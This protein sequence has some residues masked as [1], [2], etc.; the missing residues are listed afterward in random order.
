MA[1]VTLQESD[2]ARFGSLK[3]TPNSLFLPPLLSSNMGS[4]LPGVHA[5]GY[6]PHAWNFV[7]VPVAGLTYCD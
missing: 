7:T 6:C 4:Q 3:L 1:K 5:S 2:Q